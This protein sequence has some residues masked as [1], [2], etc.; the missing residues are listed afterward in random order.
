M[1]LY[2][3]PG[4]EDAPKTDTISVLVTDAND[5]TV[6]KFF[7]IDVDSTNH[8]PEITALPSADCWD[9]G[10]PYS[11][12]LEITDLDLDRIFG[13]EIVTIEVIE[14][15][16]GDIT[17]S[18]STIRGSEYDDTAVKVVV[19]SDALDIDPV[20]GRGLITIRATDASG[21]SC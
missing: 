15:A 4:V 20:N 14:P 7:I 12:T 13:E 11:D 2:G 9:M 19:Q 21:R 16:T 1:I 10:Q 17:V 18:P 3:T 5:L 6:V 8:V